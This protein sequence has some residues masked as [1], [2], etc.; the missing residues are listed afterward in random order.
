MQK[1]AVLGAG[2]W[3][4]ALAI[5][6]ANN[7][8]HTLLWGRNPERMKNMVQQSCNP[9]FLADIAFPKT[10]YPSS[11]LQQ[12]LTEAHD[13]LIAVPSHAFHSLL[14]KIYDILPNI[15]KISW[16]SKGLEQKTYKLL[17]Q[18]VFDTFGKNTT[19]AVISGPTFAREVAL[20]YPTA[21]TVAASDQH[22]AEHL[23][24]LLR[25]KTFRPYTSNDMIAIEIA[26]ACKNI[27]AIAA[28]IADGLGFGA[29]TRAALITRGLAEICRMCE[30]LGGRKETLMG[31]AGLGDLLLTCT[32]NQSR[33]R[34]MGLALAEGLS[35]SQAE[36]SIKQV[37]EGIQSALAVFN[38]AQNINVDVPIIEQVYR[39]LYQ[40]QTPQAAVSSLLSREQKPE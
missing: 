5:L 24:S 21:V 15:K 7:G 39:V 10:L 37:V 22:Y 20:N 35:V 13:I 32:D 2:S 17:H 1:I 34:R 8:H 18:L 25:S 9:Y 40:Q 19:I 14:L 36:K 6:L 33:N 23:V 3:G 11:N 27:L 12:V 28:G 38:L 31:L 16:A 26:G 29:N 30:A 4:T